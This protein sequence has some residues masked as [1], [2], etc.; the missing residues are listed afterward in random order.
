M[1]GTQY[2]PTTERAAHQR[3]YSVQLELRCEYAWALL[4]HFGVVTGEPKG[5]DAAG[6]SVLAIMPP[7]AVVARCFALAD[8]FVAECET[9]K[10]LRVLTDADVTAA[11]VRAGELDGT[12][13]HSEHEAE[14]Q[15]LKKSLD[16]L[17]AK[18][19]GDAA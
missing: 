8:A 18:A 4:N 9:R 7:A 1:D 17:D 12:L 15:R 14:M 2:W 13:L 19:G 10:G 5:E 11:F 6:R 3:G 16:N